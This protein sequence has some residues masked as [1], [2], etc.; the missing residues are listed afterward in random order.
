MTTDE[1]AAFLFREAR[2][3][4]AQRYD[5]WLA[6]YLPD[7][8]YWVPSRAD[9]ASWKDTISIV[10]DDRQLM[11]MRV[12]RLMHPHAHAVQPPARTTR[13]LGNIEIEETRADDCIVRSTFQMIEFRED[14]QLVYGGAVRHRLARRDGALAIGWKR[15]DL[16]NAAGV[17]EPITIIF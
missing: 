6:L 13:I 14:R 16:V 5:E 4:D 11:E 2:L 1:V 17:H 3:L 10:Y 15:V 7:A 8:W 9:Q 12:R